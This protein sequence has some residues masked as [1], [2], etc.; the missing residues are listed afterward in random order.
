[1]YKT[2]HFTPE[3]EHHIIAMKK[4]TT[5]KTGSLREPHGAA[6]AGRSNASSAGEKLN[7]PTVRIGSGKQKRE[8]AAIAGK[9]KPKKEAR[10]QRV[11][12]A[13]LDDSEFYNR[14]VSDQLRS[15]ADGIALDSEQEFIIESYSDPRDFFRNLTDD[16]DLVYSDY[17]LGNG[18]TGQDIIRMT[19][20]KC[21]DCTV[22][23]L[24]QNRNTNTAV[25]AIN[26]GAEKFI[27]K[28]RNTLPKTCFFLDDFLKGKYH[29]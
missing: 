25:D 15:Y 12:I 1:M 29:A 3:P 10:K 2:L 14:L 21:T 4:K 24:S 6:R 13:V 8:P 5:K 11:K 9:A 27:F 26:Q 16:I 23:I 7:K 17:Y 28:D 20:E 18:I 22:V 19:K